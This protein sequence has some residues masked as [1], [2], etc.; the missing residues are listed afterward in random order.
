[1]DADALARAWAARRPVRALRL[2][3][4]D[5]AALI[6]ELRRVAERGPTP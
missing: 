5:L 4:A 1:M 6:E 3:P 2:R